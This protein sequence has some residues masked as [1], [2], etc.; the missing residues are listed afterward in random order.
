MSRRNVI[1]IGAGVAGV[2]TPFLPNL[3]ANAARVPK[4]SQP[5]A[6]I[7]PWQQSKAPFIYIFNNV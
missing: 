4:P 5:P 7:H 1:Q 6:V 2:T 3:P